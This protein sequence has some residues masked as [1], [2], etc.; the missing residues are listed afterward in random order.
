ME[1]ISFAIASVVIAG[2]A[3]DG[4][5]RWLTAKRVESDKI[6]EEVRRIAPEL[7]KLQQK[8]LDMGNKLAIRR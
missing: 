5:R 8:V 2:L 6:V 3:W 1:T 7:A 4:F